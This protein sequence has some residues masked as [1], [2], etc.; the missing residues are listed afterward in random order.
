MI[1]FIEQKQYIWKQIK[2]F[3][4]ETLLFYEKL[5]SKQHELRDALSK[6]FL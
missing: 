2:L 6:E 1:T 5:L 4:P 3:S